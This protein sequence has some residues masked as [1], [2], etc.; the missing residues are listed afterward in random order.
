ML[1][2]EAAHNPKYYSLNNTREVLY[3]RHNHR[4]TRE[5]HGWAIGSQKL[6]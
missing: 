4:T 6:T 2:E 5:S 3:S 1:G